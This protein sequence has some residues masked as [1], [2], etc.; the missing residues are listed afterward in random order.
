MY[1]TAQGKE[2]ENASGKSVFSYGKVL[3]DDA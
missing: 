3:A 2:G 1:I